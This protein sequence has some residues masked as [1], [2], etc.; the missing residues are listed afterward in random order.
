MKNESTPIYG[1]ATEAIDAGLRKYMLDLFGNMSAGL[2]LT[3][4]VAYAVASSPAAIGFI[5]SS[6]IIPIL[7][8]IATLGMVLYLSAR[9][10]KMSAQTART[11]FISY[12]ALNGVTLSSIFLVYT[13]TSIVSTFFVAAAMFLSMT[14]YG[15][16]TDRDLTKFGSLLFMG[17]VGLI[18][19][20]IVN[21]FLHNS[22]F[23]LA[24][25]AIGVVLFTGLTAYDMQRIKSF[26][27]ESDG[28]EIAE[29]KAIF[30]ALALYLD[31]INLFLHIL[32][33]L[34]DRRD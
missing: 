3:A 22:G 27:L 6:P 12:A 26:Y 16:A 17:L 33:L 14:I 13:G 4:F 28:T 7:L 1:K 23:S 20:S 29:K 31:F 30:G 24:I 25:S 5:F 10:H 21:L 34:G 15:Y 32:R 9:I 2:A 19:A 11:L 8:M 18:I